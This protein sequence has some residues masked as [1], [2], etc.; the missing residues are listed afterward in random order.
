MFS[1]RL[2]FCKGSG[3]SYYRPIR[4]SVHSLLGGGYLCE[5]FGEVLGHD[6][7][8][9]DRVIRIEYSRQHL[10]PKSFQESIL[11]TQGQLGERYLRRVQSARERQGFLGLEQHRISY[12]DE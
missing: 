9:G 2:A 4:Q 3:Q 6:S 7:F 8:R 1:C 10:H 12:H 5:G 11:S